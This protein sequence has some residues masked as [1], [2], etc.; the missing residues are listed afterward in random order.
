MSRRNK[1][2]L[3]SAS[4]VATTK[5]K[6]KNI[7]AFAGFELSPHPY[8]VE[9]LFVE[10]TKEQLDNSAVQ[11]V[12]FST[13][14][15]WKLDRLQA[16]VNNSPTTSAIIK[17]KVAYSCGDGFNVEPAATNDILPIVRESRIKEIDLAQAET[18][19]DWA[20][21]VNYNGDN[22]EDLTAKV[23][24]DLYSFGNCFIELK[25]L[26]KGSTKAF[27]MSVLP[28]TYCRPKKAPKD[29]LN[30]TH[31]GVSSDFEEGYAITP[32]KVVDLPLYP[33]F[34]KIDGIERS[35]VH[36]KFYEPTMQYWGIPDWVSAKIWAEL[37]YRIPKFNQSKFENG[38]TPSAIISLFGSTDSEEA[39][40]V[41]NALKNCFTGT[42]N[43]SK[44]FVQ[45]LRDETS[46]ADVQILNSQE[47]G[48]FMELQAMA[49]QSIV[50]A[51]RWKASLAGIQTAGSL[52]SNQQIRSEFDVVFTDVIRNVQ[53]KVLNKFLNPALQD[54]GEWLGYDWTNLSLD[55][56][57]AY[58]VSFAGDIEV[59]Q[60]LT[61]D[62]LRK[63]LGFAPLDNPTTDI[64]NGDTN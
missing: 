1:K 44:M 28:I 22:L 11:Y 51:H 47:K 37:E 31:V 7:Q 35:I 49:A 59:T 30:P 62:E 27:T 23:F 19:N 43:N 26:K 14:D 36:L 54:A 57:K 29:Q 20:K 25:K 8:Q 38:F 33:V 4:T 17:Q 24:M 13:F 50:T 53:R 61:Q 48:E 10:P 6:T 5:T 21:Q 64:D 39:Q 12:P 56:S 55:I 15:Y 41:V 60:V 32:Q 52:G 3:H 42:G 16:I 46:K 40:E 34:E 45:A 63:E 2:G 58:P 9:D 18:L